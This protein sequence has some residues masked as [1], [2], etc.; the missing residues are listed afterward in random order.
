MPG[1]RGLWKTRDPGVYGKHR[2]TAAGTKHSPK[3]SLK[4]TLGLKA[5]V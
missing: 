5:L 3:H 2:V 1:C 4:L